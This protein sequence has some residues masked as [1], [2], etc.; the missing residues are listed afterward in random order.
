MVRFPSPA[1]FRRFKADPA[2]NVMSFLIAIYLFNLTAIQ[3]FLISLDAAKLVRIS[4]MERL[5]SFA[6]EQKLV[7]LD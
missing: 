7:R 2:F 6:L 1:S 5:A 3:N 4:A